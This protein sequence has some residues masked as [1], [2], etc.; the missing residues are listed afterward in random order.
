MLRKPPID[1]EGADKIWFTDPQ[2]GII[3]VDDIMGA[4][5]ERQKASQLAAAQQGQAIVGT[6]QE[7]QA[8]DEAE[9]DPSAL[10]PE[11]LQQMLDEIENE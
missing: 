8:L 6:A 2:Y 11:L 3:P 5:R 7:N 9:G 4:V 10:D 1:A